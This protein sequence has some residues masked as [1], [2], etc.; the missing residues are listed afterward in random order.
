MP[1]IGS[2]DKMWTEY[3]QNDDLDM[4]ITGTSLCYSC[5]DCKV[6]DSEL[7]IH[8]YNM[9]TAAQELNNSYDAIE[10]A[11]NDY[12]IKRVI[13]TFS[14]LNLVEYMNVR[15]ETAFFRG[16]IKNLPLGKKIKEMFAF[17]FNKRYFSEPVSINF[18]FPWIYT[19]V[20]FRPKKIFN[21]AIGKF[22]KINLTEEE[23][24]AQTNV[25]STNVINYNTIGNENSKTTYVGVKFNYGKVSNEAFE[26]LK[27][28]SDLCKKHNV[29]F[30]LANPPKPVFDI[31]C[32]GDEY[33]E[34]YDYIY[35]FAKSQGFDYFDFNLLRPEI[36]I[37]EEDYYKDFEHM[38]LKGQQAFSKSFA[39]FLKL[40]DKGKDLNTLFYNKYDF[41]DSINYI[42][43]IYF[44]TQT[45]SE[46]GITV[47]INSYTGPNVKILYEVMIK[48]PDDSDY[49]IIQE[50]SENSSIDYLPKKHGN[51]LIRVNAK[52]LDSENLFDRYYED[53][54]F[55]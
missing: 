4:V 33:F 38:N 20:T 31:L 49:K 50:Y 14:Y 15:A 21:N 39:E 32:Y 46:K 44:D 23:L 42:S 2:S 36:F 43:C 3:R 30:I 25:P 19:H 51:Y 40:R 47:N 24:Y 22:K 54:I 5:L 52:T 28:I 11:I 9:A 10:S 41:Y 55:Y 6:I 26:E 45:S 37:N 29:D 1:S 34:L 8:S 7:G 35:N 53:K 12:D 17:A 48:T 16:K 18:V 27:K 13:L